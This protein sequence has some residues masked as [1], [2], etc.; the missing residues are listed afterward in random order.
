MSLIQAKDLNLNIHNQKILNNLNFEANTGEILGIIG[1]SGSGKS[2]TANSIIQL[3]PHG[4]SLR[5]EIIF[6]N[7]NLLKISED[8]MCNIRGK[9]IG[10][11]F[12]E[13]M[14]AL[15]PLKNIGD[16]VSEVIK[17]HLNITL[18]DSIQMAAK[19]LQRVGLPQE[20]FPLTRYPFELSGGQRQRVVIAM[21][22]AIKPK[23]LIADEPSTAL[24]VTTQAKL[25]QLLK[26]L[27]SEDDLCLIMITHD[28]AVIAE[29]AD[30]IIIMKEGEIIESGSINILKNG[31]KSVYSK[32]LFAASDYRSKNINKKSSE[33]ALLEVKNVSRDYSDNSISFFKS[34]KIFKAVNNVSFNINYN[35]NVGLVGESGC[36]KSTIT[37]AIL[38]LDPISQGKITL[39]ADEIKAENVDNEIRKKIQVVFQDPFGSFNPRH[40]VFKLV[41]E[42]LFLQKEKV[43]EKE[44]YALVEDLLLRVGLKA[45][46]SKKYIHEFSGG[47][48]QRIAIARSLIVKPKLIILDEAV[49]ALDVS[50]R[51]QILDL[52]VELSENFGLSY[53]FISHDLSLVQSITTKVLVMKSGEIIE[54]GE[55]ADVFKFPKHEYTKTLLDSSPN[56]QKALKKL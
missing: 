16:Q 29:M 42:P 25:I 11:I 23:L 1:E 31:L 13:P 37:R 27:V 4:A 20:K 52:L 24:D 28:L 3:L 8:K 43:K 18:K 36:G 55:T 15:N 56:L 48:R 54:A 2:M 33:R 26:K 22:I 10:F 21:A 12:Q 19:V 44:K 9:D 6:D 40:N 47:Q 32:T 49:S 41:S 17:L 30:K 51:A 7:K 50:I 53:L 35:E 45:S 34:K 14:T 5:G 46:D 39:E 38:G